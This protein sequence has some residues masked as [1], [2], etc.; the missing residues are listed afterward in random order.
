MT[1]LVVLRAFNRF[2]GRENAYKVSFELKN[3]P[4]SLVARHLVDASSSSRRDY[5]WQR[6]PLRQGKWIT[7]IVP[8]FDFGRRTADKQ[9]CQ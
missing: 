8:L 5:R 7:E 2:H 1:G 6:E 9:V 4:T 3:L